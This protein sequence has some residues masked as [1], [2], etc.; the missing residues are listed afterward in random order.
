MAK[1]KEKHRAYGK[2][3]QIR[4]IE[5]DMSQ[6]ELAKLVGVDPR[7]IAD[8]IHGSRPLYELRGNINR[9]PRKLNSPSFRLI[10]S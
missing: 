4:L 9:P 5:V 3:V 7:R 8:I 6:K 10:F 1:A 2:Q